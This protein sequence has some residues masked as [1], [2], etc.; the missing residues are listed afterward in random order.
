[1]TWADT[2]DS[3]HRRGDIAAQVRDLARRGVEAGVD[4]DE[5]QRA[6]VS[7]VVEHLDHDRDDAAAVYG[8]IATAI[9]AAR[10]APRRRFVE[11]PDVI[12]KG[13]RK[14]QPIAW[15][16]RNIRALCDAYDAT[17]RYN[18]MTHRLEVETPAIQCAP[19]RRENFELTWYRHTALSHGMKPDQAAEYLPLIAAEYHP[20]RDWILSQTWDGRDRVSELVGTIESADPLAPVLIRKWLYQCVAALET[21]TDFRPSGVLVFQGPQGVGKTSWVRA[22]APPDRR[23]IAIGMGL[24][25]SS[26]DDVQTLTRYWI[27]EL[28]EL[29]AT[30]RRADV[31]ALKA[32]VDRDRD[33][34][35]SAYARREEEIP[36]RTILFASVNRRDFL[37]DDTG[38]RRWWTVR[39]TGCDFRHGIDTAQLWA[40]IWHERQAGADYRLTDEELQQ[41]AEQNTES[42]VIDPLACDLWAQWQP[43]EADTPSTRLSLRQI[44]ERLPEGYQG[45]QYMRTCRAVARLLR[46]ADV[47]EGKDKRTRALW[48]AVEPRAL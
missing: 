43:A 44:V 12:D 19:E 9:R 20:V 28:G 13:Q 46:G 23:W 3:E 16:L 8:V 10:Q 35:R 38:N 15:S 39:V 45:S 48:F 41:L 6:L 1:M 29:D 40:Q 21:D 32:F 18:T 22:L 42:E 36:R 27:A 31:A 26:R 17:V 2:L 47:R 11:F 4:V 14:G 34:Y 5:L 25:P 33:T 30:F 37:A 24:D 7:W